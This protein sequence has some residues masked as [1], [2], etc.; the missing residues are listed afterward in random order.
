MRFQ[1]IWRTSLRQLD[2]IDVIDSYTSILVQQLSLT[3]S[4]MNQACYCEVMQS[5]LGSRSLNDRASHS[6]CP[7]RLLVAGN[8]KSLCKMTPDP[9]GISVVHIPR[10]SGCLSCPT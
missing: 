9:G 2:D 3:M 4:L 8:A 1:L 5:F 10:R 6:Y 7:A